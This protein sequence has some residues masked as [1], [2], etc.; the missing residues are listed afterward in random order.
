[1]GFS[2]GLGY[3]HPSNGDNVVSSMVGGM[4]TVRNGD[5]PMKTGDR[6][7]WYFYFERDCFSENGVRNLSIHSNGSTYGSADPYYSQRRGKMLQQNGMYDRKC[8]PGGLDKIAQTSGKLPI[9]LIKPFFEGFGLSG[10]Y[11]FDR[12]RVI[13]KAMSNARPFDGVDILVCTQSM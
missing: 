6:V 10:I 1:M 4:M 12:V 9:A 8:G 13:G 2:L 5:F 3:A 7:M 11:P